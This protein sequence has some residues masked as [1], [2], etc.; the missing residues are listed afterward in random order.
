MSPGTHNILYLQAVET[1]VS[2]TVGVDRFKVLK[3]GQQIFEP[4]FKRFPKRFTVFVPL[5][6]TFVLLSD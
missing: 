1:V 6:S 5:T 3:L 2:K 4:V